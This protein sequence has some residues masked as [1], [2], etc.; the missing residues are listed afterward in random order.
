MQLYLTN[1][2]QILLLQFTNSVLLTV[3]PTH[4]LSSL[5]QQRLLYIVWKP[6]AT[7]VSV[8]IDNKLR[9]DKKKERR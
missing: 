3:F 6:W 2:E 8:K 9:L 7:I 1:Y 4:I 5:V